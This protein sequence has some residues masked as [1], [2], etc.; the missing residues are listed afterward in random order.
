MGFFSNLFRSRFEKALDEIN[1]TIRLKPKD[2]G[3]YFTRALAYFTQG[4]NTLGHNDK[5]IADFTGHLAE[6]YIEE[7]P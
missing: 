6:G 3:A 4:H 7:T 5:A 1:E 2:G